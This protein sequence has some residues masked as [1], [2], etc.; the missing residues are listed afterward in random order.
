MPES[1]PAAGLVEALL[2]LLSS[3][4][5]DL[6]RGCALQQKP[7]ANDDEFGRERHPQADLDGQLA[8]GAIL[9]AVEQL[10][11]PDVVRLLGGRAEQGTV[12]KDAVQESAHGARDD[13]PQRQVV[14]LEDGKSQPL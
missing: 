14:R 5:N 1:K 13:L 8:Q 12:A 4:R 10:G 6:G 9:V 2:A 7:D 3:L 11:E